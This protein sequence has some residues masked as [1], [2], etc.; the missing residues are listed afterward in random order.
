M[1]DI[2]FSRSLKEDRVNLTSAM[3]NFDDTNALVTKCCWKAYVGELE[4]DVFLE[5]FIELKECMFKM[6]ESYMKLIYYR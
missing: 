3:N 5:E 2:I 6:R 1:D 4:G